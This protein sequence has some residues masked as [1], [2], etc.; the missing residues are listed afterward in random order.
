MLTETYNF[1]PSS[2]AA[3]MM[4]RALVDLD[5][6]LPNGADLILTVHD[7]VVIETTKDKA[8]EVERC[9]VDIMQ[10]AYPEIM[11]ATVNPKLLKEFFP[12]GWWCPADGHFGANW[13]ACK[14]EVK[15]DYDAEHELR[16]S[17]GIKTPDVAGL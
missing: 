12:N 10:Q 7:E 4:Y 9:T 13:K 5:R 3:D 6:Q 11:D 2:T 17:L 15:E 1:P 14:P 8:A 16:K